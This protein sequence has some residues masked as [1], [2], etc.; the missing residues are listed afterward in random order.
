MIL[1]VVLIDSQYVVASTVNTS[2]LNPAGRIIDL[3]IKLPLRA[4]ASMSLYYLLR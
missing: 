3:L 1:A 2:I 4:S